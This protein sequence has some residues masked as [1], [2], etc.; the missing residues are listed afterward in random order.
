MIRPRKS[1]VGT[2]I[3]GIEIDGLLKKFARRFDA[4]WIRVKNVL[5]AALDKFPGIQAL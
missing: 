5:V 4:F 1:S 3:V 2:G